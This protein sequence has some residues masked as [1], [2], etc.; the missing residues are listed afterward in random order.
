MDTNRGRERLTRSGIGDWLCLRVKCHLMLDDLISMHNHWSEAVDMKKKDNMRRLSSV[1]VDLE[2]GDCLS[3]MGQLSRDW[4][5]KE[6]GRDG[7][8]DLC[9]CLCLWL[10]TLGSPA[11]H[12]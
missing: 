4:S 8:A 1:N 11:R 9:P 12:A 10:T 2:V 3:V 7:G 5:A 6:S